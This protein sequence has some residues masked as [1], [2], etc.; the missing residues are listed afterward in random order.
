MEEYLQRIDALSQQAHKFQSYE[1][2]EDLETMIQAVRAV[3]QDLSREL[4]ECQRLR[5]ITARAQSF[6]AKLVDLL[7]NAEQMMVYAQLR[8]R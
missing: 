7:T 1:A 5:K 2:R 4:V 8:Y 3:A 6:E